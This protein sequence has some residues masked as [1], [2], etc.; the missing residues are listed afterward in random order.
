MNPQE[1]IKSIGEKLQLLLKR[2]ETL[3]LENERLMAELMPAKK[4][5]IG[6]MNQITA[7]E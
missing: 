1:Q 5:E 2:Y 7:L 3:Q 6:L 4:R